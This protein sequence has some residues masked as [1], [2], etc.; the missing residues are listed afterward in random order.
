MPE[1]SRADQTREL[2]DAMLSRLREDAS[3]RDA[4]V[5]D[6]A[7][8]MRSFGF[9][10]DVID[11][12]LRGKAEVVGHDFETPCRAAFVPYPSC[13]YTNACYKTIFWYW[14]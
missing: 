7:A 6:P 14:Y 3:F 10:A 2:V 4:V 1:S 8:A 13:Y 12:V 11:Y 5:A 9:E